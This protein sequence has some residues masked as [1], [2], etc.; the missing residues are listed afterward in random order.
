MGV[1]HVEITE[2]V[3]SVGVFDPVQ[4]LPAINGISPSGDVFYNSLETLIKAI[5]GARV[6]ILQE[7]RR[8][9]ASAWARATATRM[10]G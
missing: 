6:R 4:R 8:R 5:F 3:P 9:P 1:N 7:R 2:E 10:R